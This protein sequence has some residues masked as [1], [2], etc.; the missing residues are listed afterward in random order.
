MELTPDRVP[1][2]AVVTL[3]LVSVLP[4][5]LSLG[6]FRPL[7][8]DGGFPRV[9]VVDSFLHTGLEWAALSAAFFACVLTVFHFRHTRHGVL[10]VL[11]LSMLTACVVDGFHL[12][13]VEGQIET[14]ASPEQFIAV[15]WTLSRLAH[16]LILMAG[17]IVVLLRPKFLRMRNREV[18]FGVL[19]IAVALGSYAAL[20]SLSFHSEFL[21][22]VRPGAL[23]KRPYDLLPVVPL[24]VSGSLLA[25]VFSRSLHS[26]F[27]TALFL[28]LVPAISAQLYMAFGSDLVGDPAANS[29]HL[30]KAVSYLIPFLGLLFEYQATYAMLRDRSQSLVQLN[31]RLN[32]QAT[33]DALT[34][35]PNRVS[36]E[37]QVSRA[38]SLA[39]R[40]QNYAAVLL[41]DLDGFKDVNDSAGHEAGDL[42]LTTTA[43]RLAASVRASDVVSRLGGDEFTIL[44]GD[45]PRQEFAAVVARQLIDSISKPTIH[46]GKELMVTPSIGI[47]TFPTDGDNVEALM[48]AAD[49][50]MYEIK[51]SGGRGFRYFDSSTDQVARDL[52]AL[53][54]DLRRGV[55]EDEFVLHYQPQI[56]I[57]RQTLVGAEALVRWNHPE[58]GLLPPGRFLEAA[59]Q[60]GLIVELGSWVL[61]AAAQQQSRWA[62]DL[63]PLRMGINV[64]FR[65]IRESDFARGARQIIAES[66]ADPGRIDLELTE[67]WIME[68][69]ESAIQHL[70]PLKELGM[71]VA[72][73]DFGTGYS[74][75]WALDKL[76]LDTLKVD[77]SFVTDIHE[78][79]SRQAMVRGILTIAEGLG[80]EVIAEGIERDVELRWLTEN[81]V[82]FG[83]GYYFAAPMPADDFE[84]WAEDWEIEKV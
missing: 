52:V 64:S 27:G 66:G 72:V 24:V 7:G 33:H 31:E 30:L 84:A 50:A 55:E 80:L 8:A 6:T 29:A 14:A 13:A 79:S 9:P 15:S 28:S 36:F 58:H 19:G 25:A 22:W 71:R 49:H 26:P 54:T 18:L 45:L 42:I 74:T 78:N 16:S 61:K 32:H 46:Q 23:I 35:L 73:D 65:Q 63:G 62:A 51:R 3:G 81:G 38:I 60:T 34:G 82:R 69:Q 40:S 53:R 37:Y 12:L 11:G 67:T 39:D 20:T 10:P 1:M 57:H 44:L 2:R 76:P 21:N 41:L 4:V 56:D 17:L 47:A 77:R 70:T 68:D 43:E 75:L 83:Q 48:R 59:E 5:F